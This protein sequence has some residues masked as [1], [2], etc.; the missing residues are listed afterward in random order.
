MAVSTEPETSFVQ[1]M[2]DRCEIRRLERSISGIEKIMEQ[3]KAEL[4]ELGALNLI[5]QCIC[6]R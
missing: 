6:L 5:S 3:M 1:R 4:E 2:R